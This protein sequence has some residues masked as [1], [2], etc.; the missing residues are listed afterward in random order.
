MKNKKTIHLTYS[1][2]Y[3]LKKAVSQIIEYKSRVRDLIDNPEEEVKDIYLK[4]LEKLDQKLEK[5]MLNE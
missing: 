2:L 5:I 4:N 1:E 3:T